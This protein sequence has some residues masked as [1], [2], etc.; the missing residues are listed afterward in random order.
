[1]VKNRQAQSPEED[2]RHP[3]F[4]RGSRQ[5]HLFIGGMK[6]TIFAHDMGHR[7]QIGC[8]AHRGVL[9]FKHSKKSLQA[10]PGL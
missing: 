3:R 2:Q 10:C 4:N 7:V 6:L 9:G 8:V 5:I 1:L